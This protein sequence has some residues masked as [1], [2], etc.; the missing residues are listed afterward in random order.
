MLPTKPY[1]PRPKGKV[2]RGL[3]DVQENALKGRRFARLDAPK[4][5]GLDGEKTVADTGIHGTTRR[6]VSALFTE[7]ERAAL[8]RLP[9]ERLPCFC[10]GRRLVHGDGPVEVERAFYAVPPE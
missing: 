1:T 7:V 10:E 8:P 2:E 5:F 6:H 3:D 9:R 4:R